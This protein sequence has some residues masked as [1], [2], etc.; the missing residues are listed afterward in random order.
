M[1][2]AVGIL[3][4]VTLGGFALFAVLLQRIDNRIDRFETKFDGLE[5]KFHTEF[6]GLRR[7]LAEEFRAP[8]APRPPLTSRPSPTRL[9]RPGNDPEARRRIVIYATSSMPFVVV[10]QKSLVTAN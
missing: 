10:K 6:A 1:E 8:S 7:D 9:R 2:I 5:T 3:A 4:A